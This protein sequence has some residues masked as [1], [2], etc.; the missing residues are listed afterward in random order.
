MDEHFESNLKK[1][2]QSSYQIKTTSQ[3]ILSAYHEQKESAKKAK[4]Y[5]GP[6]YTAMGALA[7]AVIALAIYIP[8]SLSPK[9]PTTSVD[10]VGS[11]SDINVSPLADQQATFTYEASSLYPLLKKSQAIAKGGSTLPLR[12][13]ERSASDG[14]T[15]SSS[16]K[17][18]FEEVVDTYEKVESSVRDAFTSNKNN[19][20]VEKGNF[21]FQNV[22]Y[23]YKGVLGESGTLYFNV[24]FSNNV[25]SLINGMMV[26]EEAKLY[27]L[28]GRNL[29]TQ[30]MNNM[31]LQLYSSEDNYWVRVAQQSSK[32]MFHFSYQI[33]EDSA[34]EYSFSIAL[35]QAAS[36]NKVVEVNYYLPEDE[37]SGFFRVT[38]EDDDHYLIYGA[39]LGKISLTYKN[40]ERTYTYGSFVINED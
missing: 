12:Q 3:D 32:G 21:S 37:K 38:R 5:K 22:S 33:Y 20:P 13:S 31:E 26:D 23:D 19:F 16:G 10:P 7:C 18:A 34:L 17:E 30:G 36:L 8:V 24:T 9:S 11:L 4:S 29:S 2:A 40:G 1:A 25:W 35:L 27:T 6:F 14:E 28:K 39:Y 15:S